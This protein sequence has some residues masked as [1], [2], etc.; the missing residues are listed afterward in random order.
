[1]KVLFIQFSSGDLERCADSRS[2]SLQPVALVLSGERAPQQTRQ[3]SGDARQ[4]ERDPVT[5]LQTRNVSGG[6][7]PATEKGE[8][9]EEGA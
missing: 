2:Q 8:G 1:M 3:A 4:S 5:I 6:A 7:E 9:A